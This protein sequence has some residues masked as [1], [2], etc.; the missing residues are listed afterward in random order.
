MWIA[1]SLALSFGAHPIGFPMGKFRL[2]EPER[3][4]FFILEGELQRSTSRNEKSGL[5]VRGLL[6]SG[7]SEAIVMVGTCCDAPDLVGR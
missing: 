5:T 6:P 7:S 1:L 3:D 2:P 4:E